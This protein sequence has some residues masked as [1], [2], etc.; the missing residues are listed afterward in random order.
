MNS[1][2]FTLSLHDS[3]W[4]KHIIYFYYAYTQSFIIIKKRKIIDPKIDFNDS[5]ILSIDDTNHIFQ[6]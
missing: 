4:L 6:R 5:K 1:H 2:V 3:I